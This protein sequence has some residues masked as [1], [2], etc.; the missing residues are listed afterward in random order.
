MLNPNPREYHGV[1]RG[2]IL[3]EILR[4]VDPDRRTL[5]EF[6]RDEIA[7]KIDADVHIGIDESDLKRVF[8]TKLWSMSYVLLQSLIPKFIG[9]KVE[10]SFWDLYRVRYSGF[11]L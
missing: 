7:S 1:T 5:G 10:P 11:H 3:G 2:W 8:P 6:L 9:R 4:R